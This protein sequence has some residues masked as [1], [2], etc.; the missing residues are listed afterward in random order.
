[1]YLDIE[2]VHPPDVTIHK[3]REKE[4]HDKLAGLKPAPLQSPV[5]LCNIEIDDVGKDLRGVL[6]TASGPSLR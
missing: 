5:A 1:M 6:I 2:A 3:N 4:T